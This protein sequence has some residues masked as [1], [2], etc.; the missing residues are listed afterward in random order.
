MPEKRIPYPDPEQEGV[1]LVPLTRGMVAMTPLVRITG[2]L[3][4]R[5]VSLRQSTMCRTS[6]V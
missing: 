4:K 3:Y 2:L 5:S 1:H 6:R